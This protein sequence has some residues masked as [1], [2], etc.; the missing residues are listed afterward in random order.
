MEVEEV[1]LRHPWE[2]QVV[3]PRSEHPLAS[4]RPLLAE[5]EVVV[6]ARRHL[7]AHQALLLQAAPRPEHPLA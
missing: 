2:S 1:I 6:E 3:A 5:E 7:W 4:A